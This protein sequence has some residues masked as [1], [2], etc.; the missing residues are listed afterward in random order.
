[1]AQE[2]PTMQNGLMSS[3]NNLRIATKI[4]IGFGCILLIFAV[5]SVMNYRALTGV[6]NDLDIYQQR[7]EVVAVSTNSTTVPRH[8]ASRA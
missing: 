5:A 3:F 2:N 4:A 8:P 6:G 7:V 1:L